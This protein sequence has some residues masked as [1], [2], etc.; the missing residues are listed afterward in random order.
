MYQRCIK[1]R[2]TGLCQPVRPV[3]VRPHVVPAQRYESARAGSHRYCAQSDLGAGGREFES[4]H[5]D[6][7]HRNSPKREA[8]TPLMRGRCFFF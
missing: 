5:P 1:P 6:H 2:C 4:P 8:A 3:S 7:K